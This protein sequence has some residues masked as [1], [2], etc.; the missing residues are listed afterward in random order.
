M[1]EVSFYLQLFVIINPAN[2]STLFLVPWTL[3]QETR[4]RELVNDPRARNLSGSWVAE[5]LPG[6][7]S[8]G[9]IRA[10]WSL[11]ERISKS[12]VTTPSPIPFQVKDV[13]NLIA[14]DLGAIALFT[15]A[16]CSDA[17]KAQVRS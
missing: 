17:I 8:I 6:D 1:Q 16:S 14:A 15:W 9:A 4:L 11:M 7:K 12:T 2:Y 5:R 3:E 10:R 13:L